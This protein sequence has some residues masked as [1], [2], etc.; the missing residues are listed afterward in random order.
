MFML[1]VLPICHQHEYCKICLSPRPSASSYL[2]I[3]PSAPFPLKFGNKIDT[4]WGRE[5][6]DSRPQGKQT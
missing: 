6:F 1:G 3:C 2:K 5:L 4:P